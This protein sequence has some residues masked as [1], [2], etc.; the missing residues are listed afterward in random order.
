MGQPNKAIQTRC[1]SCSEPLSE[2]T[3]CHVIVGLQDR[4][5]G[6]RPLWIVRP[7]CPLCVESYYHMAIYSDY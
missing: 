2:H 4:G 5:E 1:R 7:Y 3:T 6:K